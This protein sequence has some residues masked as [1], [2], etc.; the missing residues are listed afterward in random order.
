MI[1]LRVRNLTVS[2]AYEASVATFYYP[3]RAIVA[4]LFLSLQGCAGNMFKDVLFP[5]PVAC[6]PKDAPTPPKTMSKELL[7]KM[8]AYHGVLIIGAERLELID[9]AGKADAIVQACK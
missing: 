4:L 2:P 9:Y 7:A 5:T 6:A 3:A 1:W 8:D